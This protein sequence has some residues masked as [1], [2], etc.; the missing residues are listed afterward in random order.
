MIFGDELE[1]G[2][3]ADTRNTGNVVRGVTHQ[4]LDVYKLLG[5]DAV[6][7]DEARAVEDDG[8]LVR[9]KQDCDV[10]ADELQRIAVTGQKVCLVSV[11][12][13][14]CGQRA[15]DVIS[16]IARLLRDGEAHGSR[17]FLC[18]GELHAQFIGGS[19]TACLVFGIRLMT[20]GRLLAV[21][22][23]DADVGTYRVELLFKHGDHAIYGVGVDAFLGGQ[24][25]DAVIGTV[26]DTVAVDNE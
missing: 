10:V 5:R 6:F 15:E 16:L 23:D 12:D 7:L 25:T 9:R 24:R 21:K 20:E 4:R 3:L 1:C 18:I 2:L 19:M 14:L 8:F 26:D 17:T 13:C 22:G 11:I